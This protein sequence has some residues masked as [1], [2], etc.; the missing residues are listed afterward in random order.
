MP[1]AE[2]AKVVQL[3]DLMLELGEA[4]GR[5]IEQEKVVDPDAR[6]FVMRGW[7]SFYRPFSAANRREAQ[8]AFEQALEILAAAKLFADDTPIAV[9]DPGRGR[10]KTGRPWVDTE[11]AQSTDRGDREGI[12]R[13]LPNH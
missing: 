5:R 13:T 12:R 3:L 10:T 8:R 1:E 9:L 6:D 2:I 4:V 11:V 7:A